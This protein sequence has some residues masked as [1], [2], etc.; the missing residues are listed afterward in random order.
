MAATLMAAAHAWADSSGTPTHGAAT[1]IGVRGQWVIQVAEPDGTI[2]EEREFTNALV[3][4][5]DF[6]LAMLLGGNR[7][8]GA[9]IVGLAPPAGSASPCGSALNCI[10]TELRST[11]SPAPNVAKTLSKSVVSSNLVLRGSIQV[12]GAGDIGIV[13]TALFICSN[14]PQATGPS[15]VAPAGC[16]GTAGPTTFSPISNLTAATLPSPVSVVAGQTV[17]ATVT[18]SFGTATPASAPVSR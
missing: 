9:F 8:A 15:T 11:I 17:L 3:P 7:S 4:F 13:T 18:L 2:V 1:S 6:T 12:P 14:T 10:V 16:T 5:A